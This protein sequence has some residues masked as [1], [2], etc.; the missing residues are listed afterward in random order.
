MPPMRKGWRPTSGGLS[1]AVLFVHCLL[2]CCFGQAYAKLK[3]PGTPLFTTEVVLALSVISGTAAIRSV[4]WDG[5]TK[6]TSAFV[7]LG[8]LWVAISGLGGFDSAGT[9]AFSFFAYSGFYFVVRGGV[10]TDADRWRFVQVFGIAAFVGVALGLFQ[11]QSGTPLLTTVFEE[12][13]T[14]STRWLPGEF[15]LYALLAT[16]V[17]LVTS[18]VERRMRRRSVIVLGVSAAELILAQHRSGFVALAFALLA[19]GVLL[20]GSRD[21]LNRLFKIATLLFVGLAVFVVV[22]GGDYIYATLDRVMSIGDTSDA[23]IDWRLLSWY[24]VF[25]GILDQPLGHGFATWDFLFTSFDPLTGSHNSFLDLCYRVGVPGLLIFLALP[26]LLIVSVR[27]RVQRTGASAQLLLVC[28]CACTMALLVYASFN[29]VLETPYMS[30][31]FWILMGLGAG[32]L[33]DARPEVSR[34]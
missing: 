16:A 13:T 15:A 7:A 30:I 27:Q 1:I 31:F 4:P 25:N 6:A 17:V 29:V 21:V 2:V 33:H 19:T 5:F 9:K 20:I 18:L 12:T 24:E 10:A 22:F 34:Q 14:G 11:M 3:V 28:I 26:I 32:S 8:A 23:N